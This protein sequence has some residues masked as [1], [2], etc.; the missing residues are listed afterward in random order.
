MAG[1]AMC[2]T[3]DSS[4][5]LE[6]KDSSWD[7]IDDGFSATVEYNASGDVFAWR[8]YG[9]V[10][11]FSPPESEPNGNPHDYALIYYADEDDRFVD[12]GGDNPGAFLGVFQVSN[13][14]GS[15]GAFD[16]GDV[17]TSLTINMPE[18]P[19]YNIDPFPWDEYCSEVTDDFT[20][21]CG[22][23]LWIVPCDDYDE[24][25]MTA[26]NPADYLFE[27]DFIWYDNTNHDLDPEMR[28]PDTEYSN[29]QV[30]DTVNITVKVCDYD[31]VGD[32]ED[33]KV[34]VNFTE[35]G[36]EELIVLELDEVLNCTC[37][38]YTGSVVITE[39]GEICGEVVATDPSGGYSDDYVCFTVEHGT[40][41][42]MKFHNNCD[43][44]GDEELTTVALTQMYMCEDRDY[45]NWWG[46]VD[47]FG[48]YMIRYTVHLYDEYDNHISCIN[49]ADCC[50]GFDAEVTGTDA[51]L[52]Y[53]EGERSRVIMINENNPGETTVT[54][55]CL[56]GDVPSI[57]QTVE[58]LNPIAS[59]DVTSNVDEVY[60]PDDC[61]HVDNLNISAQLLDVLGDPIMM[62]GVSVELYID[63]VPEDGGET[64][65]NGIATFEVTF[66]PP[67][68]GAVTF[69][70]WSE[71]RGGSLTLDVVD[72]V[73]DSVEICTEVNPLTYTCYTDHDTEMC[74]DGGIWTCNEFGE[75][76]ETTGYFTAGDYAGVAV[77]EVNVSSVVG[78]AYIVVDGEKTCN[79]TV[80]AGAPFTVTSCGVSISGNFTDDGF[81]CIKVLGDPIP[82]FD[83]DTIGTIIDASENVTLD[84]NGTGNMWVC[85]ETTEK[86][87]EY[88]TGDIAEVPSGRGMYALVTETEPEPA[89]D[90]EPTPTAT[91]RS[92]SRGGGGGGIYPPDPTPTPDADNETDNETEQDDPKPATAKTADAKPTVNLPGGDTTPDETED[93][94]PGGYDPTNAI[95]IVLGILALIVIGYVLYRNSQNRE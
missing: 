83:N 68:D 64:D 4:V 7:V 76:N 17:E 91:T 22:A 79:E 20:R 39:T 67:E 15:V 1:S 45:T 65:V 16:S 24:P 14:E 73:I 5:T 56:Y 60:A 89:P 51:W 34:T 52:K 19:D 35:H 47:K 71:C 23:K 86:W 74:C 61:N 26:W 29:Y 69:R 95:F 82:E 30:G 80:V 78:T 49:H 90:P 81:A 6:N 88:A 31:G 9:T 11:N 46:H 12:W 18:S 2:A 85:N 38:T 44:D 41:A 77:V 8:A 58:F 3:Y 28:E 36:I 40:C 93:E 57:S 87:T 13:A 21:C 10:P 50:D 27:T 66:G 55:N 94:A 72:P 53:D 59:I 42:Y 92:S 54:V 25:G 75:I 37:A 63:N 62:P 48:I 70:C 84:F 43:Y 32:L 33:M